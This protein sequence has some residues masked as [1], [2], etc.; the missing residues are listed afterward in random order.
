MNLCL[1]KN[2]FFCGDNHKPWVQ[3]GISEQ[4]IVKCC[5]HWTVIVTTGLQPSPDVPAGQ[6]FPFVFHKSTT[7]KGTITPGV[8]VTDTCQ[9]P[10][11]FWKP[12]WPSV[13]IVSALKC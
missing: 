7:E 6:P 5:Q 13:R 3:A 8:R 2:F 9:L 4:S 12:N 11:G 1:L 10:R